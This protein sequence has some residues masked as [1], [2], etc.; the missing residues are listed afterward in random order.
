MTSR[1]RAKPPTEN[2]KPTDLPE[3]MIEELAES[4]GVDGTTAADLFV[5]MHRELLR[6]PTR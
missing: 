1:R 3:A 5:D 6:A 2:I 4:L